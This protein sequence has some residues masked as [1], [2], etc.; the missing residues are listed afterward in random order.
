MLTVIRELAEEAEDRQASLSRRRCCRRSSRAAR[1]RSRARRS[2]WTSCARPA[3]STRAA[4]ACS[5]SS[6]GSPR[7]WPASRAG[8]AGASA[9]RGRLD[10][11][12]Q[13]LSRFRYCTVFVVEGE[14]LD[15]DAL[16]AEL[17][18]LGDSLLVV[19]DRRA[20][21]ARPHRRPGPRA[22]AR[23]RAARSRASRSRTCTADGG[24]RC[25]AAHAR[26]CSPCSRSRPGV[27]AVVPGA[28]NRRLFESL[29][30][31][32]VIEGGQTMNPRRPTSS[33]RSRRRPRPRWSCCRT[34]ER[35]PHR[36]AGGRARDE[37]GARRSRPAR[38]RP[39]S[40]RW[41]RYLPALAPRRTWRRCT[42]RSS[43]SRP[44]RSRSPRATSSSTASPCARARGSGSPRAT[45]VARRR[46]RR[47]RRGGR[48]AAARRAA[49]VLT[50]LT[51]EDAPARRRSSTGSRSGIP[52]VEL[53][54][55]DGGQPHYPLLLSAE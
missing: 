38:S 8:G 14:G 23:R 27:V 47:G 43:R 9:A 55:Q 51:G 25:R 46:L 6:A 53:E 32:R 54:V 30:A 35:D 42:R 26:C 4:P 48:R 40:R 34:T 2:S 3:S 16:E 19:G 36:R 24:A 12:H 18:P 5:R 1:T 17:E 44:A 33:P 7:R 21:G 29:G 39:G 13:E 45:A 11:V 15:A 22:L 50:L 49:R 31:T 28:G 10:A 52:S 37:A 41:S 20:Q